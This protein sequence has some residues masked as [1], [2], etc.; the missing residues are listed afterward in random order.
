MDIN[1]NNLLFYNEAM[2][3]GNA[4]NKISPSDYTSMTPYFTDVKADFDA[5]HAVTPSTEEN[6]HAVTN[7]T[8]A[9][10]V[11][12]KWNKTKTIYN[13]SESFL[14][15]LDGT[16]DSKSYASIF[17]KMPFP[18]FAMNLPKNLG[19][20]WCVVYT[21][22]Y[23]LLDGKTGTHILVYF[24]YDDCRHCGFCHTPCEDGAN[25]D[26]SIM[27]VQ[28]EKLQ[29]YDGTELDDEERYQSA[30]LQATVSYYVVRACY[31]LASK[32]AEIKEVKLPKNKRPLVRVLKNEPPK[33]VNINTYDVGY[34]IGKAFEQQLRHREDEISCS[35]QMQGAPTSRTVRSHVRRAHW[36]HYWVGEGRTRLEVRWIEPVFV[37]GDMAA[38]AVSHRV[39]GIGL[40]QNHTN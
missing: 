25:F 4:L 22:P 30:A 17:A 37:M 26:K 13:F 8:V 2:R 14:A 5:A 29:E 21:E 40:Y 38:D 19:V 24:T 33:R 12:H 39:T 1:I 3:R 35:E 36:H 32:N 6:A 16:E 23:T 31:Y 20:D 11:F 27:D 34:R 10:Y 15:A 9:R 18:C 7:A 28:I